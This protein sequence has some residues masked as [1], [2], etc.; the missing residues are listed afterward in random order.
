MQSSSSS[1]ELEPLR[2]HYSIMLFTPLINTVLYKF[3]LYYLVIINGYVILVLHSFKL[4]MPTLVFVLWQLI[5]NDGRLL[6]YLL[7]IDIQ[8]PGNCCFSL[9][10]LSFYISGTIHRDSIH[11]EN[12]TRGSGST[13]LHTI[14][15]TWQIVQ[16]AMV[17]GFHCLG[18]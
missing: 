6:F 5:C 4:N 13:Q 18:L 12:F 7:C 8:W 16:E 11:M 14:N 3:H 17:V 2:R 9:M 15:K 10:F 1:L